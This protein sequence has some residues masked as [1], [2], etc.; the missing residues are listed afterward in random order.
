MIQGKKESN[1]RRRHSQHSENTHGAAFGAVELGALSPG[2]KTWGKWHGTTTTAARLGAERR[3]PRRGRCYLP[4]ARCSGRHVACIQ[5]GFMVL[6]AATMP[7]RRRMPAV[8]GIGPC[9]SR[10][11][12]R[13]WAGPLRYLK[14]VRCQCQ[15]TMLPISH[16]AAHMH[17]DTWHCH[18]LKSR[19]KLSAIGVFL[20]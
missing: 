19:L 5:I 14:H 15:C 4:A 12:A 11:L 10:R 2:H 13:S 3:G 1:W 7:W 16:S 8:R 17:E 20:S 18:E 6:T 9:I